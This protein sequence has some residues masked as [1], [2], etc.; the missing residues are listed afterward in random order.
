MLGP[1]FNQGSQVQV[2]A[3]TEPCTCPTRRRHLFFGYTTDAMVIARSTDGGSTFQTK[4]LA[5]VYDDLDCYP[6][7]AG[8]QT[9]TNMHFRLNSYP[10]MSVDP[11]TGEISLA[12]TDQEGSG[13]CGHGGSSFAGTTSTPVSLIHAQW[14]SI[15]TAAVMRVTNTAPD[16]VFPS[17]ASRNGTDRR[18]VLHA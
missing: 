7:Y 15:G 13:T 12:W 8:R 17:V 9:L 4:E 3:Q 10:S 1:P 18:H 6:I 14:A 5:R 16:K 2:R 11:I